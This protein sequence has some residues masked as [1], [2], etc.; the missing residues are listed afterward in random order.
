MNRKEKI[1][2]RL[3]EHY[4]YLISLGYEVICLCLQGSQNY[5][6]DEY[7]EEYMSDIDTK[8]IV[9]PHLD[10][11][12][13]AASPVSTTIIMD[14]NEHIDVKDIRIMFDMFKKMNISYIELLYTEFK[15]INPEWA[16]LI[17]P[18]FANKELVS[19]RNRIQFIKCIYGMATEKRKAL[20]HPYPNTIE[21]IEKYG[22]DG[23][24]L[25]HCARL[26]N[27]ISRY[28]EGNE[29]LESCYKIDGEEKVFLMNLKKQKDANGNFLEMNA[30][31]ELCDEYVEAIEEIKNEVLEYESEVI[32][33]EAD[34]VMRDILLNIMKKKM[35]KDL[36]K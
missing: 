9:L 11:F 31:I 20:C 29:P 16:D 26:F 34:E 19:S 8:A 12:I 14:N 27:F 5:N 1:I 2:N 3:Q 24:Q 6:L 18:L 28:V 32:K 23:K 35:I 30:A 7:S 4:N 22:Y 10:D 36:M 13:M 33:H 15:I 21:K 17:E 25:H